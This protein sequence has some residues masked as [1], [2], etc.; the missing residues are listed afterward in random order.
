MA[1][2]NK[3]MV[4]PI[5]FK[6]FSE[7]WVGNQ[8]GERVEFFSGL[9]YSPSN[10][11][12]GVGTLVLRSSN[13]K[14]GEVVEAD[15][16]YVDSKIVNS[17]N[18]EVGDIAVVVRNGSRS[19]I[20]KH[21]Q[22][23]VK[24]DNTVI[25]AF[26][27]GI[28]SQRPAFTN[29]LLDT[30]QFDNEIAKNL[31]ATINQI[32]TGSFKK[33]M[34]H[35]PEPAEQTQIGLYFKELDQMIELHQRKHEK[36]LTLKKAMLKKMFPQNG[37]TTP[38]IRFKG[39]SKA[40]EEKKLGDICDSYSGGTPSVGSREYYNGTIPFIR[41]GEINSNSTELALTEIGLKN[42]SAKMVEKG[43]IL[44]ALYGATSGESGISHIAGAI[45][46]AILAIKPLAGY[47]SF[48]LAT[49]FINKKESILST[50]LQGGQGN[51]SGNIIK[52]LDVTTP[53]LEEQKKIGTYFRQMDELIEQHGTQLTKLKQIKTACLEKMFI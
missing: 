42:S 28:H 5:R 26:M 36:L 53:I 32:T 40:W 30:V 39:F 14:N 10:V 6:G 20:G 18:V 9:T 15:N 4:P 19:L 52:N 31:G 21:A 43:D 38:E 34:F 22:I 50:Y 13:V 23:K 12:N 35:F 3:K 37:A 41:S 27:T 47:C 16:V 45:N 29:A 24:M 8:L 11:Q 7:D 33:M 49:W 51:L 44:Y 2:Q 46:Q 1:E 48:F 17:K 25:G